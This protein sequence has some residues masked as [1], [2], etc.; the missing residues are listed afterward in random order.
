M[1]VVH[2]TVAWGPAVDAAAAIICLKPYRR[3]FLEQ[4]GISSTFVE[5]NLFAFTKRGSGN[6]QVLLLPLIDYL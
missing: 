6:G 5:P 3:A 2:Y 1:S 4:F